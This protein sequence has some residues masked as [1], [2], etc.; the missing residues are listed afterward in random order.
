MILYSQ[1]KNKI[2]FNFFCN[3]IRN[4]TSV[5]IGNMYM[6]E[7]VVLILGVWTSGIVYC[8]MMNVCAHVNEA[9]YY[10]IVKLIKYKNF[11]W[12]GARDE[13]NGE[14]KKRCR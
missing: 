8:K 13:T 6:G 3:Y 11:V 1:K 14:T 5:T 2:K 7:Y 4:S 9:F 10:E 12:V